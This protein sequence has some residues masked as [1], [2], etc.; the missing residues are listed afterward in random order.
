M[1]SDDEHLFTCLLVIFLGISWYI[2][3]EVSWRNVCSNRLLNFLI[4][5]FVFLLSYKNSLYI[6][7][8]SPLSDTQFADIFSCSVGCLFTFMVVTS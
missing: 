7:E 8:A 3:G 5:L 2:T 6:P 1:T 4:D